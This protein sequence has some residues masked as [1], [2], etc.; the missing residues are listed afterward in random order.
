MPVATGTLRYQHMQIPGERLQALQVSE[1]PRVEIATAKDIAALGELRLRTGWYAST[2]LL[3]ALVTW[4]HACVLLIRARAVDPGSSHPDEIIASTSAI[5]AGQVGVIGNVVVDAEFR[6]RGLA[7]ITTSTALEWL[8]GRQVSTVLLDATS[9]GRPLYTQLGF[10]PVGRSWYTR[11]RLDMLDR[12]RLVELAG[13]TRAETHP[14]RDLILTSEL[15]RRAFG[16]DRTELLALMLQLPHNW[17]V[18]ARESPDGDPIGYLI[19]G[20]LRDTLPLHTHPSMH[21]GPL[22]AR[23]Q[24][25]AAALLLAMSYEDAP[26]RLVLP[27]SVHSDVEVRASMPGVARENLEFY[28]SAGLELHEDDVLMQLNLQASGPAS[29][30]H[31]S[32]VKSTQLERLPPSPY[33][34]DPGQVYAWLAPMSF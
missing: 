7:R 10:L 2:E 29:V 12:R 8:R 27:P 5:A 33:P 9:D 14:Q 26:W 32:T 24:A 11:T 1:T 28:R 15:D 31:F 13:A 4:E 18:I 17:L 20:G 16:G 19:Y 23:D 6:R 30:S 34:G 25:T 22:I 3:G 21:L